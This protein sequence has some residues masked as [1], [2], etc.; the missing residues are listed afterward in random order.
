MQFALSSGMLDLFSFIFFLGLSR[1]TFFIS[2]LVRDS[3]IFYKELDLELAK[4]F[5]EQDYER[6][7]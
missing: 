2:E 6:H 5:L 3:S 1:R 7:Q 4:V